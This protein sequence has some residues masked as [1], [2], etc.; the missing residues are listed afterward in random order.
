MMCKLKQS[1]CNVLPSESQK[2][3]DGSKTIR[4]NQVEEWVGHVFVY[5]NCEVHGLIACDGETA[6][7]TLQTQMEGPDQRLFLIPPVIVGQRYQ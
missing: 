3:C 5:Q 1:V 2:L 6:V 4:R 7:C